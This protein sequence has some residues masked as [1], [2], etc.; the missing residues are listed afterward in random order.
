MAMGYSNTQQIYYD[1]QTD[2]VRS[3]SLLTFNS[4]M[5]NLLPSDWIGV[6]LYECAC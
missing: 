6:S 1:M 5:M 2:D 3:C 4:M